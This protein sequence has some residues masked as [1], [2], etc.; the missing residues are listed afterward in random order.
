MLL[1]WTTC[2]KPCEEEWFTY[3]MS[4]GYEY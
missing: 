2:S 4:Y 1:H 3:E